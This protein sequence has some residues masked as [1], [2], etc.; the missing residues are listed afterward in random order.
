MSITQI[1][2]VEQSLMVALHNTTEVL[3]QVT[4]ER[5]ALRADAKRYRWLFGARTAEECAS[6]DIGLK[7]PFAQDLVLADL[8][9]FYSHKELVDDMI[10]TAMKGK[11]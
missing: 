8:S 6:E 1:T 3:K 10:D 7:P 2:P 9:G 11:S 4:A 5:D